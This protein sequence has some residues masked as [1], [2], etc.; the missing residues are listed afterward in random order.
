MKNKIFAIGPLILLLVTSTIAWQLIGAEKSA[1]DVIFKTITGKQ[2]TL[3]SLKGKPVIVAFWATDCP[4]CIKEI[5]AL[6]DLYNQ[7]HQQGLEIFAVAMSYN[8]PN[9]VV[10]MSKKLSI[11]YNIVLDPKSQL[12][13]QFGNIS[14]IP[15]TFLISARGKI[16]VDK[17]G[18]FSSNTF[19]QL[20][21]NN[22]RG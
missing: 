2:I 5:P 12:A 11:P 9:L 19:K 10:E 20:I 16:I 15:R 13:K 7:Y 21:S 22:L 1:P 8:P 4:S 14:A 6:I 17:L 3:A 18:L